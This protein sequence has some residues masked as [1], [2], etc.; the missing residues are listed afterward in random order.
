M[1]DHLV[2]EAPKVKTPQL[3]KKRRSAVPKKMRGQALTL[4]QVSSKDSEVQ[5]DSDDPEESLSKEELAEI[6]K[7]ANQE[8]GLDQNG[9]LIQNKTE[10]IQ[11]TTAISTVPNVT[12]DS[13]SQLNSSTNSSQNQSL[14][15][16]KKAEVYSP[17]QN[18][19]DKQ[20]T[21]SA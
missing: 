12:K 16:E 9:E 2:D 7:Q 17:S 18:P 20:F 8:A 13:I 19:F 15:N 6:E 1:S 10:E 4:A 21:Q 14:G 3:N 11:N 5:G